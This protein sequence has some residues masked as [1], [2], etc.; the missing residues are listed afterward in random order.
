MQGLLLR[1]QDFLVHQFEDLELVMASPEGRQRLLLLPYDALR[2]ILG[3]PSLKVAS[4]NTALAAAAGWLHANAAQDS[5]MLLS[6]AGGSSSSSSNNCSS[7]GATGLGAAV[8]VKAAAGGDV[9]AQSVYSSALYNSSSSNGVTENTGGSNAAA[10]AAAGGTG[11]TT[12]KAGQHATQNGAAQPALAPTQAQQQQQQAPVAASGTISLLLDL[13]QVLRLCQC[14]YTYV[15]HVLPQLPLFKDEPGLVAGL[16][17]EVLRFRAASKLRRK[18]L[19]AEAAAAAAAAAAAST[20]GLSGH[21]LA[22]LDHHHSQQQQQQQQQGVQAPAGA[23]GSD[24]SG[25]AGRGAVG[26]A[27]PGKEGGWG[28]RHTAAGAGAAAAAAAA[29][30]AAPCLGWRSGAPVDAA[31]LQCQ[32]RPVSAMTNL[33]FSFTF[34][35]QDLA[36]QKAGGQGGSSGG[37]GGGS[38]GGSSSGSSGVD[39]MARLLGLTPQQQSDTPTVISDDQYFAGY[40]WNLVA[41]ADGFVGVSWRVLLPGG[42]DVPVAAPHLGQ[43]QQQPLAAVV[44]GGASEAWG[45][46]RQQCIGSLRLFGP[47]CAGFRS[48]EVA[49]TFSITGSSLSR[50]QRSS[51]SSGSLAAA[52][53]AGSSGGG[54]APAV[55]PAAAGVGS[56]GAAAAAAAGVSKPG[57]KADQAGSISPGGASISRAVQQQQQ[58]QQSQ[59]SP[60]KG[61]KVLGRA[62]SEVQ[63]VPAHCAWGFPDFSPAGWEGLKGPDGKVCLRCQIKHRE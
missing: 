7:A 39:L 49:V 43:Q 26:R 41:A 1:A 6:S 33:D 14:S 3:H 28:D 23:S 57:S 12:N 13:C 59:G 40:V 32:P 45:S 55:A 38:S 16:Q 52:A 11:T 36:E 30:V 21:H 58:Q 4:E 44:P 15:L 25:E 54:V 50:V 29:A 61:S 5:S 19:A 22:G 51:S 56:A 53:A 62:Y 8:G 60:N 2:A 24:S 46:S 18:R 17:F 63:F 42:V 47:D 10:G 48:P 20:A 34:D 35:P 9:C 27:G 37:A 31:L